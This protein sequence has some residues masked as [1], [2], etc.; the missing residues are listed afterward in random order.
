MCYQL[1]EQFLIKMPNV[2]V[3]HNYVLS[4]DFPEIPATTLNTKSFL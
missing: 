2:N 1:A 4:D 3:F